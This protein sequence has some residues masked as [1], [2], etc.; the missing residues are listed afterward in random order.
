MPPSLLTLGALLSPWLVIPVA[1]LVLLFISAHVLSVQVTPMPPAQRRLRTASGM[2]MLL[3]AGLLA[4]GLSIGPAGLED[5]GASPAGRAAAQ[6]AA[7]IWLVIVLLLGLIVL[8]AILDASQT[9]REAVRER[10]SLRAEH[11]ASR[12]SWPAPEGTLR[13]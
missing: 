13:G 1:A 7:I 3:V 6:T 12:S 10:R 2:L 11:G 8:L 9:L 4:W 5:A